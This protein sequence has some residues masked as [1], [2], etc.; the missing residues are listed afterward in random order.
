V[1]TNVTYYRPNH[2]TFM[3]NLYPDG[4]TG[5]DDL[6][7][8]LGL[9][10]TTTCGIMVGAN[11]S[12]DL[13]DP[14]KS[15]PR[16]TLGAMFTSFATYVVFGT[17]LAATFDRRALQCENLVVQEAAI[18]ST[19]VVIGV[20]MATLSTALGAMFGAARILQAIARD[21]IVPIGYFSVGTL[22]GDEPRR[23][24]IL[25]WLFVNAF[26]HVGNGINGIAQV[27]CS[28]FLC[29]VSTFRS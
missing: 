2:Q 23:A 25:T 13:E 10:Y 9:V 27:R 15:L 1:I 4:F 26:G 11:L 19:I 21:N 7:V 17:V 14:G 8:V 29:I 28:L 20:A 3:D 5:K 22:Q 6:Q 16:G 18:S 12:G 24:V